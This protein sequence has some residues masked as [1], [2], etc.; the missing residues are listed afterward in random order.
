MTSAVQ[1]TSLDAFFGARDKIS[2]R[3]KMVYD[4]LLLGPKN[5][6]MVAADTGLPIN[7]VTPRRGELVGMGVVVEDGRAPCPFS[8]RET[9]FWRIETPWVNR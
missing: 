8:G 3:Q 9:I 1:Q 5:D 2:L 6:R 7:Q 4:S